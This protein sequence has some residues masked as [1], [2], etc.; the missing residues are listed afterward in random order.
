MWAK[1]LGSVKLAKAGDLD[2]GRLAKEFDLT[3]AEILRCVRL[4]S[5]IAATEERSLDMELLRAAATERMS[6]RK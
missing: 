3:G 6:M 4:A 2:A 5:S 1:L